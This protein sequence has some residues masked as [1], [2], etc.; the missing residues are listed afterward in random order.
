M[1]ITA[2]ACTLDLL[3]KLNKSS[4][5]STQSEHLSFGIAWEIDY[6]ANILLPDDV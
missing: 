6:S 1:L 4:L 5:F 2:G 3:T